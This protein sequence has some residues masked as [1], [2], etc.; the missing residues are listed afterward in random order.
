MLAAFVR[1]YD[2]S[3]V[4]I[5]DAEAEFWT[6]EQT[7]QAIEEY[8]PDMS[9]YRFVALRGKLKVVTDSQERA[10]AINELMSQ[11]R[12]RLSRSFLARLR[13]A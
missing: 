10:E 5:I 11:G 12:R 1:E 2:Y 4:A 13:S 3:S 6:P 9:R 7:M 8:E